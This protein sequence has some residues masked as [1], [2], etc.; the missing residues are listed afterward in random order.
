[1]YGDPGGWEEGRRQE[2]ESEWPEYRNNPVLS[3]RPAYLQQDMQMAGGVLSPSKG[4]AQ[5]KQHV[6]RVQELRQHHVHVLYA[7]GVRQPL[8]HCKQRGRGNECKFVF[9]AI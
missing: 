9:F 1:M 7:N 3:G 8:T 6:Q 5:H 4:L 2:V